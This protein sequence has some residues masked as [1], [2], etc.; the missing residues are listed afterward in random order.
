MVRKV[1]ITSPDAAVIYVVLT[2]LVF[3]LF[4]DMVRL[5]PPVPS[6]LSLAKGGNRLGPGLLFMVVYV[7]ICTVFDPKVANVY[8]DT[9]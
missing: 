9:E 5:P 1:G 7:H 8:R 2:V 6:E 3:L 4:V